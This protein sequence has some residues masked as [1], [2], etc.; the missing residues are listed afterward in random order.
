MKNRKELQDEYRQLKP[1]M[2]VFKIQN[3][4]NGKLLV[5]GS[6]NIPSLWNRYKFDLKLGSCL[7]KALQ[8][9]WK[10][11]GADNFVFE[12]LSEMEHKD[13]ADTDYKKE[14]ELL[15]QMV[16]DELKI[17]QEDIY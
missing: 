9:D 8:A 14:L 7:N 2:G 15:K 4:A 16:I 5:E 6:T 1:K 17:N 3:K 10:E 13:D 12:I 11:F